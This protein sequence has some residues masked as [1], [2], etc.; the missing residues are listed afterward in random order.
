MERGESSRMT[1]EI[2]QAIETVS[3]TDAG[4]LPLVFSAG[5]QVAVL[6]WEPGMDDPDLLT[7]VERHADTDEVFIL[8][9]GRALL[10][11]HTTQGFSLCNMQPGVIYNVKNGVWHNLLASRDASMII[12]EKRDTHINDVET[13][14]LGA[15]ERDRIL[16]DLDKIWRG[17]GDS[18]H[19]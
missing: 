17:G 16:A 7:T 13:R 3:H 9:R 18:P 1:P 12:V 4:Y 15:Q 14:T 5:W 19:M 8:T 2:A 10:I 6:N 11:S